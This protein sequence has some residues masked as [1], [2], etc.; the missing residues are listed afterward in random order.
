VKK[1]KTGQKEADL[2]KRLTEGEKQK[3]KKPKTGQ[4]SADLGK[5]SK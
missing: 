1:P 3:M 2:G 4:K 5:T